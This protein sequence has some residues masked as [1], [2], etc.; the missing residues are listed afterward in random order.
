MARR[1][2]SNDRYR[3]ESK[4]QTRKSA[5]SLKP[6]RPAGTLD[7][8]RPAPA[9]KGKAA[10]G[11][12]PKR[13][14]Q[15]LPTSPQIKRLRLVWWTLILLAFGGIAASLWAMK[16]GDR[17]VQVLGVVVELV[18]VVG[19]LGIDFYVRKLRKQLI[20][21][22]RARGRHAAGAEKPGGKDVS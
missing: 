7:T 1:S 8:S 9:Q 2:P 5:G 19:A 10:A 18:A 13:A 14:Y 17:T 21:T 15:P 22:T 20:E 16:Q 11:A 4:G 6:K 3:V 12:K